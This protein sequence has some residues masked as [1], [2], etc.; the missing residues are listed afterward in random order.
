MLPHPTAHRPSLGTV[1]YNNVSGKA[2][3]WHRTSFGI[4]AAMASEP[5]VIITFK[6][7]ASLYGILKLD[8]VCVRNT[9]TNDLS[10]ALS[11]PSEI[12]RGVKT[13][14]SVIVTNSGERQ[15]RVTPSP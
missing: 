15:L 2:D 13:P 1:D 7:T 12:H 9:Y 11:A 4:P 10:V 3:D 5:Y 6:A 14:V 8:D